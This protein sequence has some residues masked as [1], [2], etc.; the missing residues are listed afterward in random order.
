MVRSV[1]D[2]YLSGSTVGGSSSK[3]SIHSCGL[4]FVLCLVLE[5]FSSVL[6]DWT[7]GWRNQPGSKS[8]ITALFHLYLKLIWIFFPP[9]F[10]QLC[11]KRWGKVKSWD[12]FDFYNY[13]HR[14]FM[15]TDIFPPVSLPIQTFVFRWIQTVLTPWFCS[16]FHPV[17]VF[18][19]SPVQVAAVPSSHF[20][21][22]VALLPDSSQMPVLVCCRTLVQTSYKWTSVS[23]RWRRRQRRRRSLVEASCCWR[24]QWWLSWCPLLLE[25]RWG[26]QQQQVLLWWQVYLCHCWGRDERI[27]DKVIKN[28]TRVWTTFMSNDKPVQ[29][30][31]FDPLCR[32]HITFDSCLHWFFGSDRSLS[33]DGACCFSFLGLS[34]LLF[35]LRR[36]RWESRRRRGR[37]G[38]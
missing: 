2:M 18:G 35:R 3:R 13:K 26:Q 6:T 7:L 22:V 14:Q 1:Y 11:K 30:W 28:Q 32:R 5:P 20:L 4:N 34:L 27:M 24:W 37:R 33:F 21:S 36:R 17:F 15:E 12:D 29:F 23:S 9:Q 25:T 38:G 8:V 19:S 31:K 10:N 16:P